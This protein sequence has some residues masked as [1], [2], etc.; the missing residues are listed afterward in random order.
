[1]KEE[2]E[3]LLSEYQ[4][5]LRMKNYKKRGI[6]DKI[7]I[8][9][10]FLNYLEE[11][12]LKLNC[13]SYNQAYAYRESLVMSCNPDGSTRFN[14]STINGMICALRLFFKY[15]ISVNL[16][17]KNVFKEIENMKEADR[18]PKNILTIEQTKELLSSIEVKDFNDFKFM[19]IIELLYST[20]ARISEIECLRKKDI[21]LSREVINIIDDK[22][23]RDRI[24]FLTEYSRKLL[25]IY[26]SR[27]K[28][29]DYIFKHGRQRT[30]NRFVNDRLKRLSED[31]NL[32][33]ITC[34]GVRHTV[35]SQ[36]L[37][38]GAD[39]REVQEILGHKRIKN[40]EIYTR[41]AHEDLKKIIDEK[42]PRE[43]N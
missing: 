10:Y 4:I 15:L 17:F 31:K 29:E 6:E 30:L 35:A 11:N 40:T 41:L 1:M 32:P 34:H 27:F 18:I 39:L 25:K 3:R 22:E 23:R 12:N 26:I 21:D 13:F 38:K 36:L 16:V 5:W 33:R 7:R 24:A 43:R 28:D 20:A 19:V 9:G 42:H 8:A 37:K 14:P 2:Q